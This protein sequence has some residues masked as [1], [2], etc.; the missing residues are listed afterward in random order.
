MD[1][2]HSST[3]FKLN[4]NV[5]SRY[6]PTKHSLKVK[7]NASAKSI[8]CIRYNVIIKLTQILPGN[9]GLGLG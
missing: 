5:Y 9:L 8:N 2:Q 3:T 1:K 6:Y 4:T 7:G